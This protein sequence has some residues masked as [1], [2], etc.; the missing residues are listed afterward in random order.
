MKIGIL[1]TGDV[2]RTL[3]NAFLATGHQV[4]MGSRE[5]ANEKALAWA[6]EAG[7]GSVASVGT[8]ADAAKFAEVAVLGLPDERFGECVGAFVR[9]SP[10]AVWTG[11]QKL[12]DHLDSAGLAKQKWPVVWHVLADG[13][14]RTPSGKIKKN[15]LSRYEGLGN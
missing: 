2:G 11:P 8:F 15:E 7:A 14:P 10:G 12:I 4:M 1:G 6:K 9:L 5:A 3:A 13:L